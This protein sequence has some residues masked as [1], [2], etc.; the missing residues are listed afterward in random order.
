[1]IR[2]ISTF[3]VHVLP[4][5][6]RICPFLKQLKCH[7]L[8]ILNAVNSCPAPV[9]LSPNFPV[10]VILGERHKKGPRRCLGPL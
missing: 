9:T 3:L 10:K 8:E 2:I 7:G 4:V 1:M 6:D 5:A